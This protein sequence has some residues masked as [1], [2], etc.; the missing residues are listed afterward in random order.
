MTSRLADLAFAVVVAALA[1]VWGAAPASAEPGTIERIKVHGASLEGNLE[2]D[3]ADRDVLVYL[4]PSYASAPE[5]RYPVVYALHGYD[6]TAESF[7]A[8]LGAPASIDRAVAAGEDETIV[9]LPDANTLHGGSFYSSS[10]TIGDWESFIAQDLVA[11]ID[12]RYRTIP[13]QRARGLLGHSMGGYGALRIA[14]KRPGVFDSVY[15]MSPCCLRARGADPRVEA[16]IEEGMTVEQ[17]TAG[18][19]DL[20]NSFA[21]HAAWTPNPANPPFYIDVPTT[22]GSPQ[23]AVLGQLAANAL[24]IVLPQYVGALMSYD[25]V[26]LDIGEQDDLLPENQVADGLL[27]RFG[28]A[29]SFETYDGDHTSRIG[30]RFETVAIPFFLEHLARPAD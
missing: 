29:H 16:A 5:R 7:A 2:G 4:P 22:S 10:P 14:M 19:R 20:R 27:T 1:A 21:A 30:Q 8:M 28:V 24:N 26:A 13:E 23:P 15:A 11:S 9:V 3:P 17:A 12:A 25:A 18:P 6:M